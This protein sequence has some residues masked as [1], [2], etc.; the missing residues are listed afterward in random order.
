MIEMIQ[1]SVSGE[2]QFLQYYARASAVSD[3]ADGVA[4]S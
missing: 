1:K 3:T 4:A 2:R